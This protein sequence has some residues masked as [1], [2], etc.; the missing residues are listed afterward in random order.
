[1][2][3]SQGCVSTQPQGLVRPLCLAS[4]ALPCSLAHGLAILAS[5]PRNIPDLRGWSSAFRTQQRTSTSV[6]EAW[7]IAVTEERASILV[8][9]RLESRRG[10]CGPSGS[11]DP[12]RS[13]RPSRS[14]ACDTPTK[15]PQALRLR[16]PW[17]QVTNGGMHQVSAPH[18]FGTAVAVHSHRHPSCG[19]PLIN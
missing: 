10:T 12:K 8:R 15:A 5:A 19:A 17:P 13:P 7:G 11:A 2:F 14:Q 6:R 3:P 1:M 4:P 16:I 9:A 18:R